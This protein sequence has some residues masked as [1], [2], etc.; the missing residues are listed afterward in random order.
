MRLQ[1]LTMC[2]SE[3]P[4]ISVRLSERYSHD[5]SLAHLSSIMKMFHVLVFITLFGAPQMMGSSDVP[6]CLGD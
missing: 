5:T 6:F 1:T 3:T 2:F 4:M